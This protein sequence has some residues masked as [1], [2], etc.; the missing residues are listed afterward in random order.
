MIFSLNAPERLF[1]GSPMFLASIIALLILNQYKI[2]VLE[3]GFFHANQLYNIVYRL[4]LL[5]PIR[6]I[7]I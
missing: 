6:K 3:N 7:R 1:W 2:Y 4:H 5:V